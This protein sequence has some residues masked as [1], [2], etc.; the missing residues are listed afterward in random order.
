MRCA[1]LMKRWRQNRRDEPMCLA[2]AYAEV[3]QAL[4]M[5][6]TK[7]VSIEG[8]EV[9]LQDLFGKVVRI[10]GTLRFVDMEE[11]RVVIAVA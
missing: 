2:N 6:N 11:N 1:V 4:L 7:T 5:E 10:R 8:E 9:V 3:D